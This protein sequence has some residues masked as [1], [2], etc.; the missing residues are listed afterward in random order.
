[1][2]TS[3]DL[4]DL[5]SLSEARGAKVILAGDTAQ[6]QAIDRSYMPRRIRIPGVTWANDR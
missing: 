5:I 2:I 1:M 6:L 4:A 3:E